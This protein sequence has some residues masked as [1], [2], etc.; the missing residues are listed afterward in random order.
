MENFNWYMYRL[1]ISV[2]VIKM[3]L[4]YIEV[5][6]ICVENRRKFIE[7]RLKFIEVYLYYSPVG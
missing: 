4:N 6:Q 2:L 7:L 3:D 5:L 1:C